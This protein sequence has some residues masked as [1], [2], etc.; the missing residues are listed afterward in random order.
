ME[1]EENLL[2]T[3]SFTEDD[4]SS[5]ENDSLEEQL[6]R[7]EALLNEEITLREIEQSQT[8]MV[9]ESGS[10]YT[11]F[12]TSSGVVDPNYS[13]Y[14]YDYLTD[15]TIKVE[16]VGD[17]NLFEKQ[18]NEY[19]VGESLEVVGI[20]LGFIALSVAFQTSSYLLQSQPLWLN[21]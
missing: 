8:E 5:D 2:E 10:E 6:D 1:Y 13:Q 12:A 21:R 9:T 15:S 20:V 18:L 11:E 16:I 3:E 19:T 17:K 4:I 14:I 7:I